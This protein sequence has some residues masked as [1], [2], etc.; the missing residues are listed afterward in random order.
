VQQERTLADDSPSTPAVPDGLILEHVRCCVCGEDDAEPIGV[1]EDFEYDT[2]RDT[3]LAVRCRLCGLVYL[4]PRP[5]ADEFKRIYPPSYHAFAFTPEQF[6]FVYAMR[7][8][9]EARRLLAWCADLPADARILDVGCGD[10]FHL[11]LLRDFGKSSWQAEGVDVSSA[12]VAAGRARGLTIHHGDVDDLASRGERYDFA[13]LIQT[14]E[15]VADPPKVLRA[16][17]RVLR[18][19]GR[20]VVVTDNTDSIDAHRFRGRHWGG[21]HFPR[22]WNLFTKATLRRLAG[23]CGFRTRRIS[24]I[25]SPVNWVYSIR[26]SLVDYGAPRFVVEQFSLQTPLSLAAFTL[27]DTALAAFGRGAL[28]CAI[29][30]RD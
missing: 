29:F 27:L 26:N 17:R 30:E 16:I 22:H 8:R 4:N 23:H 19:G 28:L 2:S 14:I 10:G 7:R 25:V 18:A 5:V 21:Y 13:I 24:T 9:L 6:G 1:G 11:E 3:F 12:A 15:H 20:L